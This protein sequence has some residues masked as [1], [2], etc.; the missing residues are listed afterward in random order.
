MAKVCVVGAGSMSFG[1]AALK[2]LLF[3]PG[4]DGI[5]LSLHDIDGDAVARMGNLGRHVAKVRGLR[6]RVTATVDRAEALEGADVVV[7]SVTAKREEMWQRDRELG[8]RFGINH[9]A[10]NGGPGAIFH[11]ARNL[12]IIMPLVRE[13]ERRCPRAWILNYTNPV[14]RIC[15][16]I[17]RYSSMRVIGV[18]HQLDFGYF[19]AG[20]LLADRLG[21]ELPPDPRFRWED[22]SVEQH[23]HISVAAR[24]KIALLA[25][26]TNHFTWAHRV[27]FRGQRVP[28]SAVP[29]TSPVGADEMGGEGALYGALREANRAFDAGFEPFTRKIFELYDL[30]PTPGDTHLVEYLPFTHNPQRGGWERYDIQMYDFEWSRNRRQAQA[31]LTRRVAGEGELSLLEGIDTE[32][33]ELLTEALL[34][35]NGYLDEAINVPNEGQVPGLPDGAIVETP[36]IFLPAGPRPVHCPELPTPVRELCRRQTVIN[37]LAVAGTLEKDRRKLVEALALDPMVDDP[38]LPAKILDSGGM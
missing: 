17:H 4:L 28:P 25:S 21:I 27:D 36:G 10:E 24:E 20:V 7:L 1:L 37:E 29:A 14:P 26:G 33:V 15:T 23:H 6:T 18:C 35:G 2:G 34:T 13:M 16:A 22:L 5:D 12:D 32:R 31:E 38:E 30:F 3:A 11:A 8:L 19:M 9:Y